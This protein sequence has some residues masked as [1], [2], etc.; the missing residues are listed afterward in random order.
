[1][2]LSVENDVTTANASADRPHA[3]VFGASVRWAAQSFHRSGTPVLACDAFGD[4]DTRSLSVG[5]RHWGS[6]QQ[7]AEVARQWGQRHRVPAIEVSG[8]V[9]SLKPAMPWH[10][11]KSLVE[12]AGLVVP[13][14]IPAGD[15]SMSKLR[16]LAH[17]GNWL[18]KRSGSCGGL[19]VRQLNFDINR[20]FD[21]HDLI[22]QRVVGRPLGIVA[23]RQQSRT[24]VIGACRSITKKLNWTDP[25]D[26]LPFV[27]AGSVGTCRLPHLKWNCISRLAASLGDVLDLRG[28]L[29]LDFVLSRS[30]ALWCLEI[31]S[32]PSAS[33]E[34]VEWD[35]TRRE[36]LSADDSL[37]R[38]H[39][40]AINGGCPVRGNQY[41]HINHIT[42]IR[43]TQR[44]CP[45]RI[46]RV[47]YARRP[48]TVIPAQLP[49]HP[50]MLASGVRAWVTDIP[51]DR[52]DVPRNTPVVTMHLECDPN[53]PAAN[54]IRRF[55][56]Q[57]TQQLAMNRGDS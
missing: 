2:P 23:F 43:S 34:I 56:S 53:V 9:C 30:G 28:L 32:R 45:T 8:S 11:W 57:L 12:A 6:S 7:A 18:C 52:T 36:I 1:M 25:D 20:D 51:V 54:W 49:V 35:L 4:Q 33:C 42:S 5:W 46:K 19:G 41:A 17:T 21:E 26:C 15:L 50:V 22:Q 13:E 24:T 3:V 38:W 31:N 29:N 40:D 39:L 44:E 55:E 16:E 37:M 14:T 47:L 48:L 27:Y 10:Q